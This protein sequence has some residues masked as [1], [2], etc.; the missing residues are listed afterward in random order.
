[1]I[2]K[3]ARARRG[4]GTLG[5]QEPA[6]TIEPADAAET[7]AALHGAASAGEAVVIEGG[8]TLLASANPPAR[9]DVALRT[10]RLD[11]VHAYDPHDLTAGV[12]A[13][14]TL[15]AL[16]RLLG[17]HDQFVPFDAPLTAR[18]TV[19]GTVAAGW[20][21]P[22]RA[23]YGRPRDLVIGSTIALVDGTCA[24]SGGMVVKNVTGYDLGKLY[25]GSQGTLGALVR[26]NLKVLTAPAAR[27]LAL[28]PF[29]PDGRERVVAHA[30]TR[31][32]EPVALLTL[33]P[34]FAPRHLADG[35]GRPLLVALFE[36]SEA[37]VDRALRDYRSAL[38]AAGVAETRVLDDRIAAE[39]FQTIVD[40]YVAARERSV[41]FVAR[42]LPADASLRAERARSCAPDGFALE[43]LA[44]LA[45]GDVVARLTWRA[46]HDGE[47][48]E[49]VALLRA[50]LGRA[51]RI[52]GDPHAWAAVDAWGETPAAL[53]TM[54]A[55]KARFDP[56]DTLAPG[57]F[58]GGR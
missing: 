31:A 27:R 52:A 43:T 33:D 25:V 2:A 8:G 36:G 51:H 26:I 57:R 20:A 38:G 11:A 54:H 49:V 32:I 12:G 46:A 15:A 1:M 56:H 9:F 21:G 5:E 22:R 28:A 45:T 30:Q 10:R 24:S 53:A 47:L 40:G 6:R 17:E 4:A 55:I 19:G 34:G 48:P 58:L 16:A 23:T 44:D 18:A 50:A 29:E 35:E 3:G 39:A 7:A 41:T 13:G 42:G 37:L 14:M